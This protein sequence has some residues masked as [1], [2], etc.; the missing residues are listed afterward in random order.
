MAMRGASEKDGRRWSEDRPREIAY[1]MARQPS[2]AVAATAAP[3]APY[4]GMRTTD[5]TVAA[6]TA[7]PLARTSDR[8]RR[9]DRSMAP[10]SATMKLMRTAMPWICRT[11]TDG[12]NPGPA[13]TLMA[14]EA[15]TQTDAAI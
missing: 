5:R 7:S 3:R 12:R 11:G 15:P 1:A 2:A 4:D 13:T 6:N 8:Y 10:K 9:S 14:N